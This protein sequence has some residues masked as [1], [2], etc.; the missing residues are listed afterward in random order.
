[1]TIGHGWQ[2]VSCVAPFVEAFVPFAAKAGFEIGVKVRKGVLLVAGERVDVF[3]EGGL[4]SAEIGQVEGLVDFADFA[5]RIA[6]ELF[7]S[8]FGVISAGNQRTVF[9]KGIIHQ[10]ILA[11]EPIVKV[12]HVQL[13]QAMPRSHDLEGAAGGLEDREGV[14]MDVDELAFGKSSSSSLIRA[15]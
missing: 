11:D 10:P 8:D 3:L 5:D 6:F 4:E 7:E 12:R 13:L 2:L 15:V 9:E 14:A 1:M